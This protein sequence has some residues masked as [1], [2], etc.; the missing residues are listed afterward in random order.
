MYKS[1]NPALNLP[2]E[3]AQKI[4]Q[5][6]EHQIDELILLVIRRFNQLHPGLQGMFFSLPKDPNQLNEE[7]EKTIQFIRS[8]YH[9][10]EDNRTGV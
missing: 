8:V 3:L 10:S 6:T 1:Q 2:R 7:L 4:E 5:V 9:L